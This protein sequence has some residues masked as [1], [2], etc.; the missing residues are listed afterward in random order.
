VVSTQPSRHPVLAFGEPI[1]EADG[2][3]PCASGDNLTLAFEK[4]H[5]K[6]APWRLPVLGEKHVVAGPSAYYERGR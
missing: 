4:L 5:Q 3:F 2:K 6:R 1:G